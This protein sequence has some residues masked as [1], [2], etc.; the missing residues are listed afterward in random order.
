[1]FKIISIFTWLIFPAVLLAQGPAGE[2]TKGDFVEDSPVVADV[3]MYDVATSTSEGALAGSFSL[4][5]RMGQENN[6]RYGIVILDSKGTVLDTNRL[7]EIEMLKEGETKSLTF[8]WL[9]PRYFKGEVTLALVVENA[10]GL[11]LAWQNILQTTYS[12]KDAL[13]MC[14]P[15]TGAADSVVCESKKDTMLTLSYAQTMLGERTALAEK[16]VKAGVKQKITPDVPPGRYFVFI[17]DSEG[18]ISVNTINKKGTYG[19]IVNIAVYKNVLGASEVVI[20]IYG[21]GL[22][23]TSLSI[24]LTDS[25][26]AVCAESTQTLVT[27]VF[28]FPIDASCTTGA[29]TAEFKANDGSVLDTVTETFSVETFV[30]ESVTTEDVAPSVSAPAQSPLFF[31]LVSALALII[32]AVLLY[33]FKKKKLPVEVA[34]LFFI[35]FGACVPFKSAEAL[36]LNPYLFSSSKGEFAWNANLTITLNKATYA[37]GETGT[38][39]GSGI[40]T[41]DAGSAPGGFG[42]SYIYYYLNAASTY[43]AFDGEPTGGVSNP[44]ASV[45]NAPWGNTTNFSGSGSFTVS[46]VLAAGAHS[47]SLV[48]GTV[49]GDG[50]YAPCTGSPIMTGAIGFSVAIPPPVSSCDWDP[51]AYVGSNS[52]PKHNATRCTTPG[53][54]DGTPSPTYCNE[55]SEN[56]IT[57]ICC[58]SGADCYSYKCDFTASCAAPPPPPP[59]PPNTP[60]SAPTVTNPATAQINTSVTFTFTATDP[61]GDQIRYGVDWDNNGSIDQWVPGAGYVNSGTTQ[62]GS[63][64]FTTLGP[65]NVNVLTNDSNGSNSGWGTV[66]I[67][68]TAAPPGTHPVTLTPPT[69]GGTIT[70][71]GPGVTPCIAGPAPC[72]ATVPAGSTPTVT[73][74]PPGT[75][76]VQQITTG[77]APPTVVV[78]N[79]PT[80]TLPTVTGP[81]TVGATCGPAP[82]YTVTAP[83]P[84]GGGSITV[85]GPGSASCGANCTSFPPGSPVVITVNPPSGGSIQQII[86]GGTNVG[87]GPTHTIPSINGNV[88]VTANT[89]PP[90]ANITQF[91]VCNTALTVCGSTTNPTVATSTPLVIRWTATG[92]PGTECHCQGALCGSGSDFSTGATAPIT[93]TDSINAPSTPGATDTYTLSCYTIVGGVA[94]PAT[95]AHQSLTVVTTFARPELNAAQKTVKVG[96]T[97]T[98]NW[99]TNNGDEK[100]CSI[101]GGGLTNAVLIAGGGGTPETGSTNVVI[102]G[103]TT[104]TLTCAGLSDVETV[105]IIPQSWES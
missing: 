5:G 46:P 11:L 83:P 69:G 30:P 35:V 71:S 31:V 37:P 2:M 73:V 38:M 19:S 15:D 57:T 74:S 79:S 6:I 88:T 1:M 20:P 105:D 90:P 94:V 70:I 33:M 81:V 43:P 72:T 103:R 91:E 97:I 40:V 25:T 27:P 102:Q 41:G 63:F 14:G 42:T 89:I 39:I 98:L 99:D 32:L 76:V 84:T 65:R 104:F 10:D 50:C 23:G 56:G 36:T 75:D 82:T 78:T 55:P 24:K 92:A 8:M 80:Y 13:V 18:G 47:I 45:V 16:S 62:S 85:T 66:P 22:S 100:I 54:S 58:D 64:V 9:S 68:I 77:T 3:F 26:G 44:V 93:G 96:D 4:T 51:V 101:T 52:P 95:E 59:P 7:G 86:V 21:S 28:T 48:R 67:T 87:T 61:N 12:G 34:V 49:S 53:P 60:P 17:T 29:I